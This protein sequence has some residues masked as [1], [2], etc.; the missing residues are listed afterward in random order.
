MSSKSIDVT[1]KSVKN[2]LQLISWDGLNNL[3]NNMIGICSKF[4]ST[5]RNMYIAA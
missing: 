5:D 2:E 1:G 4:I 3:L